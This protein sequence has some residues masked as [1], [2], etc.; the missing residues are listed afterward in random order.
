M[1]KKRICLLTSGHPPFDERI[2]WKFGQ[3]LNEFGF[4]V[5]IF[6]STEKINKS[7]NGISIFGFDGYSYN[8]KKKIDSFYDLLNQFKPEL[9][10][11]S[12]ML[13]I[14]AA[15]K[16]KKN[17]G[18][19]K[20]IMDITEWF[21][22]NVAFK[23]N[24]VKRWIKY[25]QLL[26]PYFYILQK[27]DHLI[28]GEDS[29]KKRYNIFA[30]S[31]PKSIIGYYP[32]IKYFNYKKPDLAKEE[33]ILG[34]AGAITFERGI[35]NLLRA[36]VSVANRIPKKKF[37]LLL[38]GKFTY[39][40]EEVEFRQKTSSINNLEVEF[41]DWTDYDKM[42]SIIERMDICFDLR[43]RNFIYRNS[44][45]IKI[46]EYMACGKP[47]IYSDIK[48]IRN[49]INFDKYGF[50]INPDDE[51]EILGAI[52]NYLNKPDLANQHSINSRRLIE[53]NK[54]WES[55]SKKLIELVNKLLV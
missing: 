54:N 40:N 50:L 20:I 18:N 42:S 9:I 19:T 12:E 14:F 37:K 32:V 51:S 39:Q 21:P 13:P 16:F 36:S 46:F 26:L 55:E 47:F 22:E 48:P 31:K 27:V 7:Y 52:E 35:I 10:I 29:K 4:S 38:F 41:A 44:L 2:F 25:L 33:I 49:E 28:I 17:N 3:S 34:Y 30:R 8:K 53:E 15:L 1:D 24:G 5:S 43:E 11:C 45:P 6:C 23:F